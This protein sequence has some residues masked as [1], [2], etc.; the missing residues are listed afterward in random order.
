MWDELSSLKS[1]FQGPNLISASDMNTEL[2][3]Y[4]KK[5]RKKGKITALTCMR[6]ENNTEVKSVLLSLY[7]Y[8]R[9]SSTHLHFFDNVDKEAKDSQS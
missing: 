7:F 5:R 1:H 6:M 2:E 9:C 8:I 4:H 3:L